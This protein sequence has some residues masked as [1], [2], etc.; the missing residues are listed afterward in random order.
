MIAR[1]LLKVFFF[2]IIFSHVYLMWDCCM[3]SY[4]ESD[5]MLIMHVWDACM[6]E[7]WVDWYWCDIDFHVNAHRELLWRQEYIASRTFIPPLCPSPSPVSSSF[8]FSLP[9]STSHVLCNINH[10]PGLC[11]TCCSL[12]TTSSFISPSLRQPNGDP[13]TPD[14]VWKTPIPAQAVDGPGSPWQA[15]LYAHPYTHHKL[16]SW[17]MGRSYHSLYKYTHVKPP[18]DPSPTYL[19]C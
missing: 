7:I 15:A 13:L 4:K 17:G 11:F 14:V 9:S 1:A 19:T 10:I 2:I 5:A 6:C 3:K 12:A 16:Q 18:T 8:S